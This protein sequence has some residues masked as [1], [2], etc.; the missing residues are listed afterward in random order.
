MN[1]ETPGNWEL[2]AS[3]D[4][5]VVVYTSIICLR[6][7]DNNANADSYL[8]FSKNRFCPVK[9]MTIPLLKLMTHPVCEHSDLQFS[10][11][12]YLLV[13]LVYGVILNVHLFKVG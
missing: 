7:E 5:S 6:F 13:I 1:R 10:V 4:A 11:W 2:Y 8:I 3:V 9:G 12:G